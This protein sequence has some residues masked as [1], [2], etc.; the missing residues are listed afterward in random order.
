M[1]NTDIPKEKF[2]F[3]QV[4]KVDLKLNQKDKI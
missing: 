3:T 4:S 2:S 1:S